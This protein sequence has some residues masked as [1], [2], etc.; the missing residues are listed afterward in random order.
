MVTSKKKHSID[1]LLLLMSIKVNNSLGKT[2]SF[3]IMIRSNSVIFSQSP[4]RLKISSLT[5]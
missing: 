1:T 3:S 5:T 2:F 4:T